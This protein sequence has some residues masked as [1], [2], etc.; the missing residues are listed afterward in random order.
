MPARNTSHA[1]FRLS[2]IVALA[3]VA[4][5]A[6][7]KPVNPAFNVT[8]DQANAALRD[9]RN[10]PIP[11]T[12]P[13]VLVGGY[14][15]PSV[16]PTYLKSRFGDLTGDR[17]IVPV[18]IGFYSNFEDCRRK[19]IS[20]VDEAFP[21]ADP[22]WTA[23]VDVIGASLGGLA[24]RYAAA[25]SLDSKHP[26]R[27]RISRL[28]TICSPHTGAVLAKNGGFNDLQ[29]DM[30]PGSR[31]LKYVESCDADATY[32]LYPYARLRDQIVGARYAAP[33]GRALLWLAT[34]WYEGGHGG[35]WH[36]PRILA[37]IARR[38]RGERPFSCDSGSPLPESEERD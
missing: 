7:P 36:D 6:N 9:M 13:L 28:F 10:N 38:L 1:V 30:K 12:R 24:S 33:T 8:F 26:R 14:N 2:A 35:A 20:A 17:R 29:N 27:L 19:I 5:C 4:G 16:S 25:P 11:L 32:E 22:L 37:D 34:P 23:E 18:V 3:I 21:N 15:D 31:F